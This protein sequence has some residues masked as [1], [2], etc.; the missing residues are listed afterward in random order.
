MHSFHQPQKDDGRAVCWRA[1][2]YKKRKKTERIH[3]QQ[4]VGL[5]SSPCS[6]GLRSSR[7]ECIEGVNQRN[8]S[9]EVLRFLQPLP[10]I[11]KGRLF[12]HE[13]SIPGFEHL[14]AYREERGWCFKGA[15][16]VLSSSILPV[17]SE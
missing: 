13:C 16:A 8:E 11:M 5:L 17:E 14:C 2:V 3:V 10:V 12:V 7:M 9:V 4:G 6:E 1:C 15:C